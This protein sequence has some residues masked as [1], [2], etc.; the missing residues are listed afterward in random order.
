MCDFT[1]CEK[2]KELDCSQF[3]ADIFLKPTC[4]R[5]LIEKTADGSKVPCSARVIKPDG[6]WINTK[7]RLPEATQANE[8][9]TNTETEE[10]LVYDEHEL[11]GM[12]FYCHEEKDWY[13]G[14]GHYYEG[15]IYMWM[16][17]PEPPEAL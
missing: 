17:L 11:I 12:A 16:P 10:V 9:K 1:D 5:L 3:R 15:C 2:W 14:D 6:E 8:N 4:Y 7:D 13:R